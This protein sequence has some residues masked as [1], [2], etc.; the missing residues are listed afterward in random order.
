MNQTMF[1]IVQAMTD[2]NVRFKHFALLYTSKTPP[3]PRLM[4]KSKP[5]YK[6]SCQW[7]ALT[8]C[9]T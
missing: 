6:R 7:A 3:G 4:S 8:N 9:A 1:N 2:N 5:G